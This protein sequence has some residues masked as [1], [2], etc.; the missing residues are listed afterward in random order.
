MENG[1]LCNSLQLAPNERVCILHD[2]VGP[3]GMNCECFGISALQSCGICLLLARSPCGMR[4]MPRILDYAKEYSVENLD[5]GV[6][7]WIEPWESG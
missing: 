4:P 2:I 3:N 7:G 6:T 5:G 1:S